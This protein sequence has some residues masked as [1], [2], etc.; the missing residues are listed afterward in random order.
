MNP[1]MKVTSNAPEYQTLPPLPPLQEPSEV[2]GNYSAKAEAVVRVLKN[3]QSEEP[4]AKAL[5]FSTVQLIL[6]VS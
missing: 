6:V 4:D 2:R 1:D 3:I 5:V